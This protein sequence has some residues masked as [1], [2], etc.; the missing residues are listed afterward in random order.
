MTFKPLDDIELDEYVG[1]EKFLRTPEMSNIVF[2]FEDDKGQDVDKFHESYFFLEENAWSVDSMN[3]DVNIYELDEVLIA[4]IDNNL[5][6]GIAVRT[7]DIETF[8]IMLG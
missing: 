7:K 6:K 3:S 5:H 2:S 4:L 1:L 8:Q